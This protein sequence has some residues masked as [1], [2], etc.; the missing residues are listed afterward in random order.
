MSKRTSSPHT[1]WHFFQILAPY[2]VEKFTTF[3]LSKLNLRE[4]RG[5]APP[6][7]NIKP[8]HGRGAEHLRFSWQNAIVPRC[9]DTFAGRAPPAQGAAYN[10]WV[11]IDIAI[12]GEERAARKRAL[13]DWF[14]P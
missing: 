1:W 14:G 10:G 11:M 5:A 12:K 8:S 9:R 2:A 4:G 13:M 3:L 6:W 7:S